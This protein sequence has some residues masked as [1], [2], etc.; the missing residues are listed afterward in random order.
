[1]EHIVR[2]EDCFYEESYLRYKSHDSCFSC[3]ELLTG[4]AQ[5]STGDLLTWKRLKSPPSDHVNTPS[6]NRHDDALRLRRWTMPWPFITLSNF[7]SHS[8]MLSLK[9]HKC[10]RPLPRGRG[11]W[12]LSPSPWLPS[13]LSCKPSQSVG[14][15]GVSSIDAIIGLRD[16]VPPPSVPFCQPHTAAV[17]HFVCCGLPVLLPRLS[18]C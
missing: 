12:D 14:F 7:Q 2:M 17:I 6:L 4:P 18:G 8:P 13:F 1:M 9:S 15:Q 16:Q 11:I 10:S 3:Q 5:M